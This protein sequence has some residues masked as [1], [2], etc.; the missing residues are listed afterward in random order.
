MEEV[1][2]KIARLA[3]SVAE[4][5]GIWIAGVELAGSVRKPTVRVFIDKEGGVTLDDCATVSR[6]LSALL[7]VEDVVRSTYVLEVSSPGLDRP[8]KGKKDFGRFLGKLA[9]IVT[10]E[11]IENQN[12]FVGR[13][14]EVKENTVILKVNEKGEVEIPF[15]NVSNARLEI[16]LK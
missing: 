14:M 11:S 5:Q 3:G 6:G 7:D 9:R 1:K 13:I 16:E 12:F 2:E 10:K 4:T 15:E 8:L